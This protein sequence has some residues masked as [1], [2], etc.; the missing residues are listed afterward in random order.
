MCDTLETDTDEPTLEPTNR[1]LTAEPTFEPTT[2]DMKTPTADPTTRRNTGVCAP[3]CRKNGNPWS[4]K[5]FDFANCSGCDECGQFD[6]TR[7]PALEPTEE[8]ET[9]EPTLEPTEERETDEPTL[10]PTVEKETDE[11]TLE[12]TVERETDEPTL[13]PTVERETDEP[14]LEPTVPCVAWCARL[15]ASWDSKC[16]W[17]ACKGCDECFEESEEPEDDG[18]C[19]DWCAISSV[20]WNEG[21]C[22]WTRCEGCSECK[23]VT[24]VPTGEPTLEPEES[25]F[26]PTGEPTLEPEDSA[27]SGGCTRCVELVKDFH[28]CHNGVTMNGSPRVSSSDKCGPEAFEQCI[29]QSSRAECARA[30]VYF[31]F[32]KVDGNDES[33]ACIYSSADQCETD[34]GTGIRTNHQWQIYTYNCCEQSEE[35]AEPTAEP[36]KEP[37]ETEE[38][39][40]TPQCPGWCGTHGAPW[41][42]K[43][44]F[45]ACEVCV[46]CTS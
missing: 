16:T 9:D 3:W 15:G 23:P 4:R 8:R 35:T 34:S 20:G 38:P 13:E 10:E 2:N 45:R 27:D 43:C 36:T 11:P 1:L 32:R 41:S 30:E 17:S 18:V 14:T 6:N 21:K 25:T 26:A 29:K 24:L 40:E 5:C 7:E 28:K 44:S 33:G 42:T 12:P 31:S 37:E 22:K 19:V 46:R 39:R